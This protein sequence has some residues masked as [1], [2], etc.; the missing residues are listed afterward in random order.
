[1]K[2]RHSLGRPLWQVRGQSLAQFLAAPPR[3]LQ[4]PHA[5]HQQTSTEAIIFSNKQNKAPSVPWT[6]FK[7]PTLLWLF[8]PSPLYPHPHFLIPWPI[9]PTFPQAPCLQGLLLEF[10]FLYTLAVY[11]TGSQLPLRICAFCVA[12]PKLN[13]SADICR[14]SAPKDP[15]HWGS[16]YLAFP[17]GSLNKHLQKRGFIA[18][19]VEISRAHLSATMTRAGPGLHIVRVISAEPAS[20]ETLTSSR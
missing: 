12:P 5:C 17:W 6:L 3:V 9:L 19:T 18:K 15:S 7:L 2:Q 16:W 11:V 8:S 1:V 20:H 14:S 10:S 4:L 13:S